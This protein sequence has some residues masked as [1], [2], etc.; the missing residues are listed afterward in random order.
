[1]DADDLILIS[2]DDHVVEPPTM[3]DQH[4]PEK[5][6]GRAPRVVKTPEGGD[7]WEFE[8]VRA[9]NV[10]LNAVA[11]CPPEEYN[12]D[13]TEYTQM[14][15]GCFDVDQRIGDMSACGVLAGLNFPTFPHFCGQFFW[16]IEDKDVALAAIRAYNDWHIDEWAGSYPDR[17]IPLSLP[18]LWDPELM[19]D[20]IRRVAAKGCHAVTFSENPSK[21]GLPSYHTDH[22]A[23]F[24]TACVDEGVV[25]CLHIGSSSSM[26]VTAPDAPPDVVMA[27][28]PINSLLAVT[29]ILFSGVFNRF[30]GLQIAMSEGGVGWIPFALER[31]DYVYQHH[32]RWTGSDFGGKLPSQVFHEH[33]WTCF[34]DDPIGL[35]LRADVGVDRMMWEL[36]YPHSDSTWPSAPEILWKNLAGVPE[37][38]INNITHQNAMRAFSFDPFK[39]R[40]RDRS[41]VRALRSEAADIDISVKSM[42]R[43]KA[44]ASD[45]GALQAALLNVASKGSFSN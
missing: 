11:G 24:F 36:D 42:G 44:E 28:T 6:A 35:K 40:P 21:L 17:L 41:T 4:W 13:P 39:H 27:L 9:P 10:G 3:F 12:L 1:M 34:I 26:P 14:R 25:V 37:D 2:V 18:P 45:R 23:P 16:R 32:H 7:I 22:W 29:D 5:Y 19:A 15:P 43:R 33:F 20:E 30:P 31:A 38:E 8:G